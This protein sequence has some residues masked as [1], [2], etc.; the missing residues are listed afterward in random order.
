MKFQLSVLQGVQKVFNDREGL[1]HLS[2]VRCADLEVPMGL[3]FV[4]ALTKRLPQTFAKLRLGFALRS[5]T[6]RESFLAEIIDCRQNPLKL[7]DSTRELLDEG[8]F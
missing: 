4:G 7:V 8:S 6:I 3:E 5:V 1:C 2:L